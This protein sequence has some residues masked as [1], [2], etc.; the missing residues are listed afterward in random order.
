MSIV[1]SGEG[2]S[3]NSEFYTDTA[4]AKG[5]LQ[6]RTY[7]KVNDGPCIMFWGTGGYRTLSAIALSR[8]A[9]KMTT[10][11]GGGNGPVATF[12]YLGFTWYWCGGDWGFSSGTP[13]SDF[14]VLNIRTDGSQYLTEDSFLSVMQSAGVVLSGPAFTVAYN[15]NG[16]SGSMSDQRIDIDTPTALRA[17]T[18]TKEDATFQGWAIS[19]TGRVVYQDE[20]VVENLAGDGETITLYAVWRAAPPYIIL[21]YNETDREH[22]DKE[23][24][25]LRT[26]YGYFREEC[27]VED[28]AFIVEADPSDLAGCNYF[29]L[30][31]LNRHYFLTGW[32][33]VR[34]NLIEIRG[35]VDVLTTY[36]SQIREQRAIVKRQEND[37]AYNLYINDSSLKAYQNPYVITKAFPNG[38]EGFTYVLAV[39]GV[40]GATPVNP[41]GAIM[42]LAVASTAGTYTGYKLTF[43]WTAPADVDGYSIYMREGTDGS[44]SD[45]TNY[46]VATTWI[47]DNFIARGGVTYYFKVVATNAFD[48]RD[49]NIVS[50]SSANP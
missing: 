37:N 36:A 3:C 10:S 20:Q 8:D 38:F 26:L 9:T 30:P 39:A 11:G 41:P 18:F 28:P 13:T 1:D 14:P 7:Y 16:G 40:R 23:I 33:I 17:N 4:G 22:L 35:H 24:T 15:S 45:V 32:T 44:W 12:Q 46:F 19:P 42:D 48:T 43:T 21:Q 50:F 5:T 47:I 6:G 25:D 34:T 2:W 31:K 49:S 27:T 29:S